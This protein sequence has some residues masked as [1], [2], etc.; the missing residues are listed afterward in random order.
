MTCNLNE[1]F[2]SHGPDE[3]DSNY[4]K[5]YINSPATCKQLPF[6]S[7]VIILYLKCNC[8]RQTVGKCCLGEFLSLFLKMYTKLMRDE[9]G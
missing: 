8:I 5:K 9:I 3:Q 7:L 4:T 1:T 6:E 2:E